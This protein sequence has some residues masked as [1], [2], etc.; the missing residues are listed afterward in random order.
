MQANAESMATKGYTIEEMSEGFD[1][2]D[3]KV[4]FS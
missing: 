4:K 2:F 1:V 3:L